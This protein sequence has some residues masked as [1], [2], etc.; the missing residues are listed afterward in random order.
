VRWASAPDLWQPARLL[1]VASIVT[2]AGG[3]PIDA[4]CFGGQCSGR[5]GY[6][7]LLWGAPGA[8]AGFLA[9]RTVAGEAGGRQAVTGYAMGYWLWL[10]STGLAVAAALSFDQPRGEDR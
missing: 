5:P 3:L 1:L 8:A 4:V 2:C 7:V 10:A 9:V 6:A